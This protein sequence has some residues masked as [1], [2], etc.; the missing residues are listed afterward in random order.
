[1]QISDIPLPEEART[2]QKLKS[3]ASSALRT[4]G[5]VVAD[6]VILYGL[7]SIVAKLEANVVRLNAASEGDSELRE[8]LKQIFPESFEGP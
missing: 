2:A 4:H 5:E 1:M 3:T 7:L 8:T 6:K